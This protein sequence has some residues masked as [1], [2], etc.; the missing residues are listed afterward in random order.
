MGI[1]LSECASVLFFFLITN[2]FDRERVTFNRNQVTKLDLLFGLLRLRK[3][4]DVEANGFAK[5]I[6]RVVFIFGQ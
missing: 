5:L 3:S 1:L 4:F 2:R 6:D